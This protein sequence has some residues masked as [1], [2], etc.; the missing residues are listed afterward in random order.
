MVQAANV[1]QMLQNSGNLF[2]VFAPVNSAIQVAVENDLIMCQAEDYLDQPC[3]SLQALFNSTSLPQLVLNNSKLQKLYTTSEA[4]FTPC[5]ALSNSDT[6]PR[7]H[8]HQALMPARDVTLLCL[9][10]CKVS[11]RPQTSQMACR[12]RRLVVLSYRSALLTAACL[13]PTLAW[14]SL[15]AAKPACRC[16]TCIESPTSHCTD[17]CQSCT[18]QGL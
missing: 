12:C 9:Q 17:A 7:S 13:S 11:G 18:C 4:E 2:T 15:P 14:S 5:D 3:T 6:I 16:L 10:L 8:C 1:S